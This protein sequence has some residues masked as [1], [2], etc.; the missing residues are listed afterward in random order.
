MVSIVH[1]AIG[2]AQLTKLVAAAAVA[3]SGFPLMLRA[4][5]RG[6]PVPDVPVGLFDARLEGL[7]G[8]SPLIVE[9]RFP[10]APLTGEF[11]D[12]PRLRG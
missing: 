6:N 4:E 12:T 2:P 7:D 3:R 1:V 8:G 9:W 11:P 10:P 5:A